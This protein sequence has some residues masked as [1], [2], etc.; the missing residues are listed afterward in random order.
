[1]TSSEPLSVSIKEQA[2]IAATPDVAF[3]KLHIA[4]EGVSISDAVENVQQKT[5]ELG[6]YL[7]ETY[8]QI[9]QVD[10]YDVYFGQKQERLGV[11][12]HSFPRPLVVRGLLVTADPGDLTALHR[13]I[14][15]GV[16]KGA[17]LMN[18]Q[19]FPPYINGSLESALLFGLIAS[20]EQERRAIEECLNRAGNR[21]GRLAA[22]A[23]RELGELIDI[24]DVTVEP[25]V[26][27]PFHKEFAHVR[28][29]FP[30]R[31][32][33]TTPHKVLVVASLT[34]KYRVR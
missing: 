26:G 2:N 34:A 25:S 31:F 10:V 19:R 11:E 5:V 16:K 33:S 9:R 7:R 28:R 14:D 20:E 8:K 23:G 3:V 22:A 24:S 21:A 6:E 29:A 1:M 15:D 12:S 4:G 27:D 17:L 13:V 18:P 32:L 30:T